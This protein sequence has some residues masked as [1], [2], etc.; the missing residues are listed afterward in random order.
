MT[1][2]TGGN[3]VRSREAGAHPVMRR[4]RSTGQPGI[5]QTSTPLAG[6]V[7]ALRALA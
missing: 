2:H 3:R 1:Y 6:D 7:P 4:A 5:A